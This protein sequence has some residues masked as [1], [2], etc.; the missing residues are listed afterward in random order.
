MVLSFKD[1]VYQS[2]IIV[3]NAKQPVIIPTSKPW[4]NGDTDE[5]SR[6][7]FFDEVH[8][9]GDEILIIRWAIW[10]ITWCADGFPNELE[11]DYLGWKYQNEYYF[12][13]SSS[14]FVVARNRVLL[15][16]NHFAASF[17]RTWDLPCERNLCEEEFCCC[18]FIWSIEYWMTIAMVVLSGDRSLL[19]YAIIRR[20]L[21]SLFG[22]VH[23]RLKRI[24]GDRPLLTKDSHDSEWK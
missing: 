18:F 7:N 4:T 22:C 10:H 5:W 1:G 16:T 3:A 14:E 17:G 20:L 19:R 11:L 23:I 12:D 24:G 2:G 8:L 13:H 21:I 9:L 15:L 6:T